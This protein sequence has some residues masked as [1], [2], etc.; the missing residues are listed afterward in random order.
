MYR[1]TIGPKSARL[2]P[3][4]DP[5]NFMHE[6]YNVQQMSP[7]NMKTADT[8]LA[9]ILAN[10]PLLV[11]KKDPVNFM[12]LTSNLAI[13]QMRTLTPLSRD[14]QDKQMPSDL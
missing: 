6:P 1:L 3:N 14:G 4:K 9:H 12:H 11:P 10:F 2:V 8:N 7:D 13:F 5:V